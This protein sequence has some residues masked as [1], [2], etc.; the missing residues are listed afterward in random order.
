M[1]YFRN[2]SQCDVTFDLKINVGHTVYFRGSN[3]FAPYFE[4][5]LMDEH[6][7]LGKLVTVT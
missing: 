2:M 4:D 6:H 5:N 3:E 7:T 1:N